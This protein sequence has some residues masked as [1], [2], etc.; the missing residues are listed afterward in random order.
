YDA[1]D[2]VR[3]NVTVHAG[4][5]KIENL[6]L[7]GP[8]GSGPLGLNLIVDAGATANV[9]TWMGSGDYPGNYLADNGTVTATGNLYLRS[10]SSNPGQGALNYIGP[11]GGSI[12]L[13]YGTYYGTIS[14]SAKIIAAPYFGAGMV[15]LFGA[16]SYTGGVE[17]QP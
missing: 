7:S 8:A 13:I 1:I 6:I 4:T 10:L 14:G 16:N 15:S 12:S 3:G 2:G 11:A 9:N 5:V 17:T